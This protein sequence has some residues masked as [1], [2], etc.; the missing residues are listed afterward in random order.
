MR[1]LPNSRYIYII[2]G[3]L[4]ITLHG[5]YIYIYIYNVQCQRVKKYK[6]CVHGESYTN[7]ECKHTTYILHV[8]TYIHIYIHTF[9]PRIRKCC[10]MTVGCRTSHK[11]T[12]IL[13]FYRQNTTTINKTVFVQKK[14][15]YRAKGMFI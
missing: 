14:L 11:Y 3:V 15:I 5:T 2:F 6:H 13:N 12:N 8:H 10:K 9:I 7:H 1:G 4:S